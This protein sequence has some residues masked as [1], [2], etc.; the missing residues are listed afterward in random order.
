MHSN[1]TIIQKFMWLFLLATI[2]IFSGYS[3]ARCFSEEGLGICN[4]K[5]L[6]KLNYETKSKEIPFSIN[7]RQ[8]GRELP[9]FVELSPLRGGD[10][11]LF[12]ENGEALAISMAFSHNGETARELRPGMRAGAFS[13][14][15]S[16]DF[17]T[18]EVD[19]SQVPSSRHYYA[20]FR[21]TLTQNSLTPQ[22]VETIDFDIELHI[23]PNVV[24]R[25]LGDINLGD[26]ELAYGQAIEG[27]EDF[28]IGGIGFENYT[29]KLSSQ[30]GKTMESGIYA[31]KGISEK[32]PYSVAFSDD[33][34]GNR[35]F[36][37]NNSGEIP[38]SFI[39]NSDAS[40]IAE[41]AR[42]YVTV[43]PAAWRDIS[44][45]YYTDILTVTISSQ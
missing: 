17:L 44:E 43:A 42:I 36:S 8:N 16:Q 9:F 18:I 26:S 27:K 14:S 5:R 7:S 31:L 6:Y 40:C 21:M 23:K 2:C 38:G 34:L 22:N 33:L 10:F 30:N 12:S 41:N 15:S 4:L 29:V 20:S 32:I 3:Q 25:K 35:S 11:S 24:I 28:C 39:R 1:K 37:P 45:N 13:G 19:S